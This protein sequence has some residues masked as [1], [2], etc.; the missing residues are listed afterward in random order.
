MLVSRPRTKSSSPSD[1]SPKGK[2]T[3]KFTGPGFSNMWTNWASLLETPHPVWAQTP[4]IGPETT[5]LDMMASYPRVML[6]LYD[7]GIDLPLLSTPEL[8]VS[9]DTIT[10][11][12]S[13][14]WSDFQPTTPTISR[15]EA[16]PQ[17]HRLPDFVRDVFCF[18]TYYFVEDK[19]PSQN[20]L[21]WCFF[22]RL[23]KSLGPPVERA[24]TVGEVGDALVRYAPGEREFFCLVVF[25]LSSMI[26][27]CLAE[28]R[29]VR[30]SLRLKKI[31]SKRSYRCFPQQYNG[32]PSEGRLHPPAACSPNRSQLRNGFGVAFP[33]L[34]KA[35]AAH[36]AR[37]TLSPN[38]VDA[39]FFGPAHI[40][41]RR[42]ATVALLCRR[43]S[44]VPVIRH[45]IRSRLEEGGEGYGRS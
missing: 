1:T 26:M 18:Q 37:R 35:R 24:M 8:Y 33:G 15:R 10:F 21:T 23:K 39:L 31:R 17:T 9:S 5:L 43:R 45:G 4:N 40:S 6:A 12:V 19:T 44:R 11:L 41:A 13:R 36:S 28:K 20:Q 29:W 42:L 34:F 30:Q 14:F 27:V 32:R 22:E 16:L 2:G 38:L 25:T 7:P 3:S